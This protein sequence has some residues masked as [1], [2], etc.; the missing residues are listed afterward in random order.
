MRGQE[1]SS[2]PTHGGFSSLLVPMFLHSEAPT[3]PLQHLQNRNLPPLPAP[4]DAGS[5]RTLREPRRSRSAP[6]ARCRSTPG[7]WPSSP[8]SDASNIDQTRRARGCS[9]TCSRVCVWG[10]SSPNEPPS[11]P[12][13]KKYTQKKGSKTMSLFLFTGHGDPPTIPRKCADAGKTM[14]L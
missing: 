14:F 13:K 1:C 5:P 9:R 12:V 8:P 3:P 2:S 6:A 10:G 7:R 4:R 11:E